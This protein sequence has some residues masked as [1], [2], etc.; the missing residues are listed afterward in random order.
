MEAS[1]LFFDAE[2]GEEARV[3]CNPVKTRAATRELV[4]GTGKYI[5]DDYL[6]V[7]EGESDG[8]SDVSYDDVDGG[9]V[10][11]QSLEHQIAYPEEDLMVE[12]RPTTLRAVSSGT[13]VPAHP[14]CLRQR[15]ISPRVKSP[16]GMMLEDEQEVAGVGRSPKWL[17]SGR[18]GRVQSKVDLE[19]M[20]DVGSANYG[21]FDAGCS[22]SEELL[23][24]EC[25]DLDE[26]SDL[27]D[28]TLDV[29]S[30]STGDVASNVVRKRSSDSLSVNFNDS[31][32]TVRE[33]DDDDLNDVPPA[34]VARSPR[35]SVSEKVVY[36]GGECDNNNVFVVDA[37]SL[38][39]PP[40]YHR[41][42]SRSDTEGIRGRHRPPAAAQR[43]VADHDGRVGSDARAVR[44]ARGER[45][46]HP[47]GPA[48]GSATTIGG[49]RR[50]HHPSSA[51]GAFATDALN[52]RAD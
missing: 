38:V 34:R 8:G 6:P 4:N 43:G 22:P 52:V 26:F 28:D 17:V 41:V 32:N 45:S 40:R 1:N 49:S 23:Y 35:D 10:F 9:E 14:V 12:R 3:V 21:S 25:S 33:F 11:E 39:Q 31:L 5:N 36:D 7:L 48:T 27:L 30:V 46:P 19:S 42:V 2:G 18:A 47:V 13:D 44:V 37:V 16:S 20:P 50:S 15:S 29:D 51:A 24:P